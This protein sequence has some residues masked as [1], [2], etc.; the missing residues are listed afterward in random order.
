MNLNTAATRI[1]PAAAPAP[2]GTQPAAD[3][4]PKVEFVFE[5]RVTLAPAVVLGETLPC[6]S[7]C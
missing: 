5:E 2:L 1:A 6:R 3:I 7:N 4:L